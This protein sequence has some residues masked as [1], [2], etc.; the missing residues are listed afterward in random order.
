MSVFFNFKKV[1]HLLAESRPEKTGETKEER[2]SQVAAHQKLVTSIVKFF[3]EAGVCAVQCDELG[4][5]P[6]V[7]ALARPGPNLPLARLLLEKMLLSTQEV[8]TDRAELLVLLLL[9]HFLRNIPLKV[10]GQ[11]Y[12]DPVLLAATNQLSK[13]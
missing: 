11:S 5:V 10:S 3:L 2:K 7:A 4:Q 6:L 13:T 12:T 9:A 8:E 1:L